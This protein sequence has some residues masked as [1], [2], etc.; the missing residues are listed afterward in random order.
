MQEWELRLA[1]KRLPRGP[2][3]MMAADG[4]ISCSLNCDTCATRAA[5]SIRFPDCRLD[6][7]QSFAEEFQGYIRLPE[8]ILFSFSIHLLRRKRTR[9]KPCILT[10]LSRSEITD[11]KSMY[12]C[13]KSCTPFNGQR[14]GD[15]FELDTPEV[16]DARWKNL[17]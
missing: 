2:L 12:S 5:S 3:E 8:F 9:C 10:F 6:A 1:S 13:Q 11:R 17:S 7:W 16:M 15:Y 14:P 4:K